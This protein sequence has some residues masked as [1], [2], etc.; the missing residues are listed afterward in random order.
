MEVVWFVVQVLVIFAV[1]V[2]M[3]RL[4]S[5]NHQG[6]PD[7]GNSFEPASSRR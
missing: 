3:F 1:L 6:S 5:E 4:R 2:A 7:R